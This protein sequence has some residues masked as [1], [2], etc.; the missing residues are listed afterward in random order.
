MLKIKQLKAEPGNQQEFDGL[1]RSARVRLQDAHLQGLSLESRFDLAYNSSHA[2]ALAALRWHGLRSDNRYIV[3]QCLQHTLGLQPD[4]WRILSHC[5][6]VRNRGEYEGDLD[7]NKQLVIDLIAASD[8]LL[9]QVEG[10]AP[11]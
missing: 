8:L 4:V 10:L 1:V 2:L 7:I 6:N 3:F 11:L 9:Q 5:H